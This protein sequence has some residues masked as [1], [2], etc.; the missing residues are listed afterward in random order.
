M[1]GLSQLELAG[2]ERGPAPAQGT[3][4]ASRAGGKAARR[5][6]PR[7]ASIWGTRQKVLL[8]GALIATAGL[9]LG[10]TFY[11]FRPRIVDAELMPPIQ[12]WAIWRDLSHGIDQR[13]AWEARYLEMLATYHR[14]MIVA[15][16]IAGIGVIVM[17]SS[18]LA[19]K[20]RRKRRAR[21]PP[22][23]GGRLARSPER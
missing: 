5:S 21:R 23:R 17:A 20:R 13:P 2:S 3:A 15:A 6:D 9:G 8:V 10:A 14:W 22:N 18:L 1:R 7:R 19:P 16:A 11:V 4:S 12:S